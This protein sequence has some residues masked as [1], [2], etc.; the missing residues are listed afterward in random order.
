MSS[1]HMI[2]VNITFYLWAAL[3]IS[4]SLIPLIREQ[5][6]WLRAWTYARLQMLVLIGLTA[7]GLYMW[8]DVGAWP[9]QVLMAL[10][11]VCAIICLYDIY[12]FTWFARKHVPSLKPG[13]AHKS[14]SLMVANVLMDNEN[15]DAM[16]DKVRAK[17]PDILFLVETNKKW[18][19]A[20]E[21]LE[22]IYPHRYLLPLEN[23]N[24]MLFYSKYP[25]LKVQERYLV[26]DHIPSLTI[27][28]DVGGSAPLHFYGVHPRPPRVED[29]TAD[30]DK[31][32]LFIA[33]EAGHIT[34]P[35]LVTGDLNDVGWSSTTKQFLRVSGLK[36]PRRGRGLYNSYNAKNPL[37]RWPLDHI[38]ISKHFAVKSM[39]RLEASGSDHFPILA[40]FALLE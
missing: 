6:F 9:E 27:D 34:A 10:L 32:L 20:L 30:L 23:Y 26:Q 38:F 3:I 17:T 25:I 5:T 13:Q 8:K 11:G 1:G 29:D 18:A 21:A 15:Y 40:E 22:T 19:D 7:L 4:G 24:G 16:L 37:V 31:E 2:F 14:V 36:D 39:T 28:L 33:H 35:V 12:P